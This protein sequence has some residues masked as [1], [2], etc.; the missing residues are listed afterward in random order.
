MG[1]RY[2]QLYLAFF[3]SFAVHWSQ[4]YNVARRDCGE[5]AFFMSQPVIITVEDFLQWVWRR[6]VD[7]ERRESLAL[8]EYRVGYAWTIAAF[9]FTLMPAI[10]GWVD[11]GLIGGAGPDEVVALRLG[12]QLGAA[13]LRG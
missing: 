12:R 1:S 6:S 8:L 4:A 11:I 9:T 7:P 13:Y 10:T 3:L 5:L 2:L